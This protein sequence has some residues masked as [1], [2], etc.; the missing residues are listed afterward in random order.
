M[1][2]KISF[3][4]NWLGRQC[5]QFIE[6][7]MQAEQE[8]CNTMVGLFD[9]SN[10]KVHSQHSKII[11]SLQYCKLGRHSG[12]KAEEWKGRVKTAGAKFYDKEVDS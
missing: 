1:T 6:F 11:K 2:Q 4:K 5:L 9:T 7:L 12:D 8:L 10:N 3:I